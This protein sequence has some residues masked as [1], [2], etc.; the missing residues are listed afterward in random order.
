[1]LSTV[2]IV[3]AWVVNECYQLDMTNTLMRPRF[4]TATARRLQLRLAGIAEAAR[5]KAVS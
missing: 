4:L 5:L 3:V 1:M 2:K